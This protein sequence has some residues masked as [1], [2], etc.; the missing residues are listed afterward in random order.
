MPIEQHP[1]TA[2]SCCALPSPGGW[3]LSRGPRARS[4]WKYSYIPVGSKQQQ[5]RIKLGEPLQCLVV[6]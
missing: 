5:P 2:V 1:G 3:L 4:A 6:A